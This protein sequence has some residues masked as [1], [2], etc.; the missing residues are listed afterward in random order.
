MFFLDTNFIYYLTNC[1]SNY[2]IDPQ[3]KEF[4]KD[5]DYDISYYSIFEIANNT[6][7]RDKFF[8]I[9][10][11][12]FKN[13]PHYHLVTHSQ[14]DN[15][16]SDQEFY[17]L[18][19]NKN[20]TELKMRLIPYI[21]DQYVYFFQYR[22]DYIIALYLNLINYEKSREHSQLQQKF[23]DR[24]TKYL[25]WIL[26][27]ELNYLIYNDLFC[28]KKL[29]ELYNN[30]VYNI[31]Y[32]FKKLFKIAN[33]YANCN[34]KSALNGLRYYYKH[35][36]L[37]KRVDGKLKQKPEKWKFN[38]YANPINTIKS[39]A[40]LQFPLLS[41]SD[42]N[43]Q[44]KNYLKNIICLKNNTS[45]LEKIFL[46]IQYSNIFMAENTVYTNDFIDFLCLALYLINSRHK[47]NEN[48]L[49]LTS[50]KDFIKWMSK[51]NDENI[52][53]SYKFIKQ[54]IYN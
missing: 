45:Q 49:F 4:I 1:D 39:F 43:E 23:F 26:T 41:E 18:F 5:N 36:L 38:I 44:V 30:L 14:F 37:I 53:N 11:Y 6:N 50:D 9:F 15:Y 34:K 48:Y 29:K 33:N 25:K 8:E 28:E 16:I 7:R 42:L 3:I 27:E 46:E 21:K 31:I 22:L 40:K 51:I 24:N 12:L 52:Q 17:S 13:Y 47:V 2:N 20:L 19:Q 35:K 54:I 10:D 32:N